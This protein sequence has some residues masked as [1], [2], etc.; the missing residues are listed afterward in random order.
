[1]VIP[2]ARAR[3]QTTIPLP[4]VGPDKNQR[5]ENNESDSLVCIEREGGDHTR[6][7]RQVELGS[8]AIVNV[9]THSTGAGGLL[10]YVHYLL[11]LVE[12]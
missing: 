9:M 12:M 6:R 5:S 4:K 7:E 11:R 2:R 10:K 8:K 1:M 3:A